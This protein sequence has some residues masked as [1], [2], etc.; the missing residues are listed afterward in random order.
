MK[1]EVKFDGCRRRTTRH[2]Q[3]LMVVAF[4]SAIVMRYCLA[5]Q[6]DEKNGFPLTAAM[7]WRKAAE[8]LAPITPISDRCW[9]EWERIMRLP[10]RLAGPIGAF[11]YSWPTPDTEATAAGAVLENVPLAAAA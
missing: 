10:R 6:R 7:E 3:Q 9:R 2:L 11:K 4:S 5:A 1:T 8:L